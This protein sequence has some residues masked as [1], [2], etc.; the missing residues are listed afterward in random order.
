MR[1]P[2]GSGYIIFPPSLG[3]SHLAGKLSWTMIPIVVFPQ[4]PPPLMTVVEVLGFELVV[5]RGVH[6]VIEAL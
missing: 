2:G 1:C 3:G 6:V 5:V 4:S